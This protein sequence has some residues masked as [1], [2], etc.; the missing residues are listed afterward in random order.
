MEDAL[1]L[2]AENDF[3]D[4]YKNNLLYCT[5]FQNLLFCASSDCTVSLRNYLLSRI[6]I[7]L[8]LAVIFPCILLLIFYFL[9]MMLILMLIRY[10]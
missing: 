10:Y 7:V 2:E 9:L 5:V 4:C 3:M 1:L 8:L 6:V